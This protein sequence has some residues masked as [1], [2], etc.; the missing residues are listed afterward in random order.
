MP[1]TGA[2]SED[3]DRV[4]QGRERNFQFLPRARFLSFGSL[5]TLP[6]IGSTHLQVNPRFEGHK[7][8]STD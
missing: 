5:G 7:S 4:D 1:R 3:L 8:E 6:S 2:F